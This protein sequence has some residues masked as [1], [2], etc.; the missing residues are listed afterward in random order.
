[1]SQE[2]QQ[3]LASLRH[4][5][6]AAQVERCL[7]EKLEAATTTE[8][9]ERQANGEKVEIRLSRGFS[10]PLSHRETPDAWQPSLENASGGSL[11]LL[12]T[13]AD[14]PENM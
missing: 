3:V 14:T 10:D 13:G 4:E 7:A 2:L 8:P 11:P 12:L 1:M 6:V 9:N 5:Q